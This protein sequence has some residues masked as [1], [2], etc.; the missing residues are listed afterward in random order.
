[1]GP[2]KKHKGSRML[3]QVKRELAQEE[4][5]KAQ[6][7]EPDGASAPIVNVKKKSR[8]K[9]K[10]ERESIGASEASEVLPLAEQAQLKKGK[11]SL[12]KGGKAS[13]KAHN[14]RAKLNLKH[15]GS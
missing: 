14:G 11:S 4:A 7:A 3:R 2:V 13:R 8:R 15:K 12:S 10:G 1:M 5:A 9:S 6:A